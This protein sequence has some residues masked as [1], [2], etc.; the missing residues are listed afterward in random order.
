MK[1]T[2]S[3]VTIS[4]N[5]AAEIE[6]TIQS[7]LTQTYTDYEYVFIDGASKDRTVEIIES[8]REAFE[9]KGI[10]YRVYSEPDKGIYDAMNK[11]IDKTCGEWTLM[12]NAGDVFVDASVLMDVFDGIGYDADVVYGNTVFQETCKGITY[13]KRVPARSLNRFDE[14]MTFCHQSVFVRSEVL[15]KYPFDMSFKIVADFDQFT[16]MLRDGVPFAHIDTYVSVF[17]GSGVSM[18]KPEATLQEYDRV[19]KHEG[20]TPK[21]KFVVK[22]F[23]GVKYRLRNV[24]RNCLPQLFYSSRRG[25]MKT[26]PV[27]MNL[28]QN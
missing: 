18:Q 3:I 13:Y 23:M 27:D 24:V 15:K 6:K 12:L 20:V 1:T 8:Y 26:K 16:R 9:A 28:H 25:W 7:V 5:A 2:V 22:V 21:R 4:Y 11:G 10:T 17:D 14:G 19:R